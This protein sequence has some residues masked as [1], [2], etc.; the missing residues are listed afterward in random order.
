ML[1]VRS[2]ICSVMR[3]PRSPCR[4]GCRRARDG[5][6]R[7]RCAGSG[8][9]PCSSGRRASPWRCRA[10]WRC[11]GSRP[12]GPWAPDRS[13]PASGEAWC[14]AWRCS[15]PRRRPRP[16]GSRRASRSRARALALAG[17][18]GDALER[19]GVGEHALDHALLAGV[20][21]GQHEH[22]V[23]L[24]DLG[25]PRPPLAITAPPGRATR[26]SCS[27]GRGAPGRPARRS[28]CR[29]GCPGC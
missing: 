7:G 23:A 14:G 3:S 6:P 28:G 21:A 2:V 11:R 17:A 25:D 5:R 9:A 22:G 26:S 10:A 19:R 18:A 8:S 13:G 12:A 16:A 24:A 20:L 29:A 1:V 4:S 27:C 15:G